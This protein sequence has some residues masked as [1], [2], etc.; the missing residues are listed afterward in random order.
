MPA[1]SRLYL[2]CHNVV[3]KRLNK[4]NKFVDLLCHIVV[5]ALTWFNSKRRLFPMGFTLVTADVT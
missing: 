3:V 1:Y 4:I 5:Q 2:S